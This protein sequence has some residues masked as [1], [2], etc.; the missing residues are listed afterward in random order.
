MVILSC[1]TTSYPQ[2][3]YQIEGQSISVLP[4]LQE[5]NLL[6]QQGNIK[7]LPKDCTFIGEHSQAT[8]S[9]LLFLMIRSLLSKV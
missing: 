7:N 9:M 2:D 6:T 1:T 3:A 5:G 8:Y 4:S